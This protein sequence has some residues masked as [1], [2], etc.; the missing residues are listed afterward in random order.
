MVD[1][2]WPCPACGE[3]LNGGSR[4]CPRCGK[5][6][7]YQEPVR[8]DNARPLNGASSKPGEGMGV[9]ALD[10]S[11]QDGAAVHAVSPVHTVGQPQAEYLVDGATTPGIGL[12]DLVGGGSVSHGAAGQGLP[13]A[14]HSQ[15][16]VG[17]SR[18]GHPFSRTMMGGMAAPTVSI[19][20]EEPTGEPDVERGFA[21][22]DAPE[23]GTGLQALSGMAVRPSEPMAFSEVRGR[24]MLGIPEPGTQDETQDAVYEGGPE[25]GLQEPGPQAVSHVG[26]DAP[27]PDPYRVQVRSPAAQREVE[28][29][30]GRGAAGSAEDGSVGIEEA[31]GRGPSNLPLYVV[32][33]L[34][35]LLIGFA[36]W[37]WS[38]QSA[39]NVQVNVVR[40]AKGEAMR[41]QV[42][43]APAGTKVRFGDREQPLKG[44]EARFPLSTSSLSVGDN[45]VVATVEYP[46]GETL[47]LRVPLHVDF[48]IYVDTSPLRAAQPRLDVV[49]AATEGTR[50]LLDGEAVKF[51]AKGVGVRAYPVDMVE[52]GR[53]GL[54]DRVFRYRVE[55]TTGEPIVGELQ[56]RVAVTM[57][58]LDTPGQTAV[59]DEVSIEL[60][61]AVARGTQ[62]RVDG[63]VVP[64]NGEG[65][66]WHVLPLPQP[67]NYR[68]RLV[69]QAPEKAPLALTL[70][71]TRVQDLAKA[72][73]SFEVNKALT[74][75]QIAQNPSMYKG[76]HVAFDGRVF[77]VKTERGR[78]VLQMLVR[79]CAAGR[80]CSLWVTYPATTRIS[81]ESWVR[82]LGT[83]EG[84][85]QFRSRRDE[86]VTVP[87]VRALF[88]LPS[89]P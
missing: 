49:V 64:V 72:A 10:A 38:G 66:F 8:P 89:K 24:T 1:A 26:H 74:Y 4:F 59:T 7:G 80:Q 58:Q 67:G 45:V 34:A 23:P 31:R 41:F 65:R 69:A 29:A 56:T 85:Q 75:G 61:G 53:A 42:H 60:A 9:A 71:I 16:A 2:N 27:V 82:V 35:V 36:A 48:R 43:G 19:S 51:D 63:H 79:D 17:S 3:Q 83:V 39:D 32:G 50:V 68:P 30:P 5:P 73:E 37:L 70:D 11:P 33:A 77:N 44:N 13:G 52:Q 86:I 76:Q 28:R 57:L 20:D 46:G 84:Q 54:V 14:Q 62:V 47:P 40:T 78:G 22:A 81:N 25:A 88:V 87:K 6:G 12:A 55:P 15:A 18:R 21:G